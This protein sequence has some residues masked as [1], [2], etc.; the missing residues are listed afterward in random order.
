MEAVNNLV[1]SYFHEPHA[2]LTNG[3]IFGRDL[4]VT[5]KFYNELKQVGL[6]HIVVLSGQN[7]SLLSNTVLSIFTP[8]LG[9]KVA[10]LVSIAI[11]FAFVIFVGIEAPTIR[12]AIMGSITL[13]GR[14]LGRKTY[15][16]YALFI[17]GAVM[18]TV[19]PL[20]IESISFQLS[21]GATL[22]IILF[23][24]KEVESSSC[25]TSAQKF[26]N[27]IGSELRTSL[28][29]SVFT[30]PI[31]FFYFRQ[32]SF[33]APLANIMISFLISPIMFWGAISVAVGLFSYEVGYLLSLPLNIPL[34]YIVFIVEQF[35][36]LPFAYLNF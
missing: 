17:T 29:A 35:S 20:Y 10:L 36:K 8:I 34:W 5:D 15:P 33:I 24:I 19:H 14:Y 2:S 1:N 9:K 26:Y 25:K 6:I 30:V 3:I 21:F 23:S 28:S 27:F 32:I 12:A 16:L 22:G 18:I 11:I 31:I 7:I 4:F 13:F